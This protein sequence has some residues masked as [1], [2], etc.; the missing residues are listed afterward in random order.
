A[1]SDPPQQPK[2]G[3]A[4]A[5][6]VKSG[7]GEAKPGEA[8]PGEAKPAEAKP[9][10]AM[11]GEGAA[12]VDVMRDSEGL[13]LKFSF[14]TP[15]PA[16]LFRRG[17]S[18]WL[19]F[20]STKSLD[21][22]QIRVNASALIGDVSRLPLENGQAIRIRLNRPQMQSL[23][24]DERESGANWTLTFADKVLAPPQPLTV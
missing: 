18:A 6:E 22:D 19:V 8:K 16:A 10:Q 9:A 3:E 2:T 7:E 15:T 5:G 17:D 21:I 14:G 23:T 11:A 1:A 20:D 4:K 12:L 13:R 24:S